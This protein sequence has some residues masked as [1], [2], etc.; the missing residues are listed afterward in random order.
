MCL[1][2]VLLFM[3]WQVK[4]KAARYEVT[5]ERDAPWW[6]KAATQQH[7]LDC[8]RSRAMQGLR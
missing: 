7:S 3:A 8:R 1:V 5:L 6:M 4:D 2:P